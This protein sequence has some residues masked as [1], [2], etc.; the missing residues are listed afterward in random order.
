MGDG[1]ALDLPALLPLHACGSS[2]SFVSLPL[3]SWRSC[4]LCRERILE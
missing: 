2:M 4:L 1:E 3:L